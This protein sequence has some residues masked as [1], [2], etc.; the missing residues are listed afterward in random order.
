MKIG[1]GVNVKLK[2]LRGVVLVMVYSV[3]FLEIVTSG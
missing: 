2:D 1:P 3:S